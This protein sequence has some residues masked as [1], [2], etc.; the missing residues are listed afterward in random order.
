M[1]GKVV[2]PVPLGRVND[3]GVVEMGHL[4]RFFKL[5]EDVDLGGH[6]LCAPIRLPPHP[7]HRLLVQEDRTQLVSRLILN[8]TKITQTVEQ[9]LEVLLTPNATL[10]GKLR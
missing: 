4:R 10:R 7:Y 6:L 5:P 2:V 9:F 3:G 1:V 8:L